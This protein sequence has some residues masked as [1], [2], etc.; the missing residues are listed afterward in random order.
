[1]NTKDIF[2]NNLVI[3][4]DFNDCSLRYPDI[5]RPFPRRSS[6]PIYITYVGG[7]MWW[8]SRACWDCVASGEKNVKPEFW[9]Y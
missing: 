6:S 3:R 2:V 5:S 4:M 1:M 9:P 8:M 7:Q